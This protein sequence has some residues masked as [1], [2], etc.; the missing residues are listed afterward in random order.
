[1]LVLE[2]VQ[3]GST[4]P[5]WECADEVFLAWMVLFMAFSVGRVNVFG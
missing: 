3:G 4:V 5:F 1:M 2:A